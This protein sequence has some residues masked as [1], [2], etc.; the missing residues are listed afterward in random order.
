M[1]RQKVIILDFG[2]QTTQ[3][4]ARR[5]REI[6]AYCEILP[7]HITLSELKTAAPSAIILSGGPAS[8]DGDGAPQ[9]MH[10]I[11]DLQIPILGICYGMQLLAKELGGRVH[12][13]SK[14]EFGRAPIHILG[15]SALFANIPSRIDVW[16]SHGDQVEEMPSSFACVAKSE[17]CAFVAFEDRE[18]RIYGVQFHPEVFHSQFGKE[19][20]ENFV[21]NIAGMKADWKMASFLDEETLHI[22]DTVGD[23]H[24]LMALSGGVDSSVAAAL[25]HRAIKDQLHCV[26]VNH[27]L[28]RSGELA[29]IQSIFQE[30]LH[31][32][33]KVVDAE[34]EFLNAL[35]GITDPE[36]K[37]KVVGRTFIEVFERE[38]KKI[39]GI[40]FLGQGTLYPDVVESVSAHGGPSAVIKSH[41]NV[42]GLPER[43]HLKLIEPL[44]QLFKDEVR[45][46]GE[47]LG[48]PNRLVHRQP[49]PG[50][51]LSIRIIGEVNKTRCDLLRK[52]DAIV[53]EEI[54]AAREQGK[55]SKNLWQWF[56]VLLPVRTVG[57][58]GDGRT[59]GETIA[60][61]CCESTDGMTADFAHIPHELL[62]VISNRII[63]E[64]HGISRVVYDISS[65][66]PST[67]EWE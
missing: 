51:G 8:V 63:N 22:K 44:R 47:Q 56:A 14:R 45:V 17:T 29:E 16:M 36:Q 49:F 1:E 21:I 30:L 61:R 38:S 53:R 11:L 31:L 52:A 32:N 66:P 6:G 4:I 48:L 13:A 10:G 65:K 7:C 41:H 3:L 42:G 5:V 43:M 58:M 39:E 19:V 67:I 50:P 20:L 35:A 60:V 15:N 33:L 12:H 2:S 59:Y 18:R 62:A 64:V 27:G 26:Y 28:Q 24:V 34:E 55:L 25:I 9:L 54:D 46:L 37:R 23:K 40:S 57:V